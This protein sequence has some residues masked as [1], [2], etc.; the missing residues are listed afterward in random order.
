MSSGNDD[1][2]LDKE[3]LPIM[4]DQRVRNAARPPLTT[5]DPITMRARA[6]AEFV[7]WNDTP[8]QL[9]RV[10]DFAIDA[11][12]HKVH[13]RLYE[14]RTNDYGG[15]L[16]YFHGGGWV[17]GDLDLEDGALRI[18]A[19]QSGL[20]V[21]S[22]DYRLAPEHRFPAALEDGETVM[23]W[24]TANGKSLGIDANRIAFGG[25]SAGANVALGTAL[26]LRDNAG[27]MPKYMALLYGAFSRGQDYPSYQEFGDGRF[28]LP[29]AAM[30]FFWNSYLGDIKDHPHAIPIYANLR[31]LPDCYILETEL[32][33]LASESGDMVSKMRAAGLEVNHQIYKGAMHGFTQYFKSRGL[34][35]KALNEIAEVLASKIGEK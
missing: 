27:S 6:A 17:I 33:V 21:L 7:P 32:D 30:N 19:K 14:P 9:D 10:T 34:A 4:L 24:L 1:F 18:I 26:R 8:Q 13:V 12:T 29:S 15:A 16:V 28:G 20:K 35:R 23:N 5:I 25:G 31:G 22:V 11:V 2:R 3:L